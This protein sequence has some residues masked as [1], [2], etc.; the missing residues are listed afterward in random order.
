MLTFN[1]KTIYITCPLRPD[2]IYKNLPFEI[3]EE[4]INQ[5]L[6]RIDEIHHFDV[7]REFDE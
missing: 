7:L 6:R 5:L 1:S 2:E 4:D 3:A